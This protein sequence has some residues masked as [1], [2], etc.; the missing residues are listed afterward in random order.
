MIVG[1]TGLIGSGKSIVA[2]A[3]REEGAILIDCDRIGREVVENN[4]II[5]Y[6]LVLAFG[7][8]ILTSEDGID[9]KELGRLA[10]SSP[11][12]TAA[13]NAIVHPALLAELDSRLKQARKNRQHTVVDAALLI[14]WNYHK[15]MDY[16]VVVAATASNRTRRLLAAGFIVA[17]I[18]Q[19]TKSQL[20]LS[21]LKK[22]ADFVILNDGDIVTV[23]RK[24][25]TLYHQLIS[26]EKG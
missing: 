4:P 13:L 15:K 11:E 25:K 26:G 17:E 8:T 24:A 20:P 3:I 2:D 23:R 12:K 14:Y 5:R 21:Y 9:R 16:T 10:F 22:Q 1:V 7:A 6:R 19:R 18:T